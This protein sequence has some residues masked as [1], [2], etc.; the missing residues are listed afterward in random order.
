MSAIAF[1]S[2]MINVCMQ[3]GEQTLARGCD[4]DDDRFHDQYL[5]I[6]ETQPPMQGSY[7]LQLLADTTDQAVRRVNDRITRLLTR[8]DEQCREIADR[9]HDIQVAYKKN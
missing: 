8:V 2:L 3:E 7:L 6:Q 1:I 5:P 9:L 4:C